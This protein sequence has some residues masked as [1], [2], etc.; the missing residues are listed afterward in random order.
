MKHPSLNFLLPAFAASF[1]LTSSANAAL[2]AGLA[3]SAFNI[4]GNPD[5]SG[6]TNVPAGADPFVSTA[7]VTVSRPEGGYFS[8]GGDDNV[9]VGD[10]VVWNRVGATAQQTD[11]ANNVFLLYRGFFYDPD[12]RFAF[13]ENI[14]DNVQIKIDGT[15]VLLNDE[16]TQGSA[17]QTPTSSLGNTGGIADGNTAWNSL[18]APQQ[19]GNFGIGWHSIEIRLG[20]FG[21]TGGPHNSGIGGVG[22]DANFGFGIAGIGNSPLPG[23]AFEDRVNYSEFSSAALAGVVTPDGGPALRYNNI[24][25]TGGTNIIIPEPAGSILALLGLGALARRR[26][27]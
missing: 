8:D 27:S 23:G 12:G 4:T 13:G 10:E 18:T 9:G 25:P 2:T 11:T 5:P 7:W 17:W 26:R 15:I 19:A 24:D 16:A 3:Y 20:E 1:A 22:W 14:D 21:G 6:Y